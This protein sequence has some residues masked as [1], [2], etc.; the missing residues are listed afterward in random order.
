VRSN[1]K[2]LLC[3]ISEWTRWKQPF[4]GWALYV[5][6]Q[7][8]SSFE[9]RIDVGE[10]VKWEPTDRFAFSVQKLTG[11]G[12]AESRVLWRSL[13]I[14]KSC[15]TGFN[16]TRRRGYDTIPVRFTVLFVY[17]TTLTSISLCVCF[18]LSAFFFFLPRITS[19]YFPFFSPFSG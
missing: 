7:Q 11:V 18:I 16:K 6:W 5:F 14:L 1:W 9:Y 12:A 10:C 3:S 19:S 17:S 4:S 15:H 2:F 13:V 8:G